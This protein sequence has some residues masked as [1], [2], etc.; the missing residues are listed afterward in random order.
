MIWCNLTPLCKFIYSFMKNDKVNNWSKEI[1]SL[2]PYIDF[3]HIK[4]K[5]NELA[6]SLSTLQVLGLHEANEPEK[7]GHEYSKSISNSE[8]EIVYS[9]GNNQMVNQG[10]E[11]EGFKH[12]FD[13]KHVDDLLLH[14]TSVNSK[15]YDP[16]SANYT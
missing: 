5:E 14:D 11:V 13:A 3:E 16:L 6:N 15:H 1:Q 8:A 2:T 9:I 4:G 10:F 12:Q 7:E